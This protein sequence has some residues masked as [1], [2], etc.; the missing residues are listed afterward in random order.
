M[1]KCDKPIAK[2]LFVQLDPQLVKYEGDRLRISIKP[3][4]FLTIRLKF[5]EYQRKFI[6]EWKAGKLRVGEVS[7][8]CTKVLVPFRKDVDLTNPDDWIA[9]DVNES[10][11]TA[12]STN[13]HIIR[14]DNNLRE[15]RSAYFEKRRRIR[16]LS[17]RKP[18]TSRRLMK[19]CSGREKNRV[20]DLLP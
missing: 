8:N 12:V 13:P 1:A 19:K 17:K 9:I 10:N 16:K 14:L 11:V 5:G 2:K 7:I 15:I 4:E 6:E 18:I 3:R 20:K